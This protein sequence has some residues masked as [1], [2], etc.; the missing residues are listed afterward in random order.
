LAPL[1]PVGGLARAVA[2]DRGVAYLGIGATVLAIDVGVPDAPRILGQ[3][4]ALGDNVFGVAVS[5]P[6]AFVA[7][8]AA[9]LYALDIGD[10]ARI[11]IVGHLDT[12]GDASDVE[13]VPAG[14]GDPAG[15]RVLVADGGDGVRVVDAADPAHL[16]V[17]ATRDTPGFAQALAVE[18]SVAVIGD[19]DGGVHVWDVGRPDAP[20]ADDIVHDLNAGLVV[21]DVAIAG[22]TVYLATRNRGLCRITLT[23]GS[24][25]SAGCYISVANDEGDPPIAV[26]TAGD[27]VYV[28]RAARGLQWVDGA[29][30]AD[31]ES[32]SAAIGGFA[33]PA[34]L[35]VAGG[36]A[37]VADAPAGL[38]VID[39]TAPIPFETAL[40]GTWG[41][42][43]AVATGAGRAY[44]ATGGSGVLVAGARAPDDVRLLGQHDTADALAALRVDGRRAYAGGGALHVLDLAD[45][46]RP[47]LL[48][49]HPGAVRD[50]APAGEVVLAVGPDHGLEV[51][52]VRVPG[53][54]RR[55]ATLALPGWPLAIARAGS[56]AY[57]ACADAGLVVVDVADPARP[58][59]LREV[60]LGGGW[61]RG[62]AIAAG[63]AYVAALGDGV[64]VLD[65]ADPAVPREVALLDT[66]GRATHVVV[67]GEIAVV[68]DGPGGVV[69]ADV[70]DPAAPRLLAAEAAPDGVAAV[71]VDGTTVFAALGASGW[72][73]YR[74]DGIAPARLTPAATATQPDPTPTASSLA[75]RGPWRAHL[76][77]VQRFRGAPRP[78]ALG[79]AIVA[80]VGGVARMVAVSG[81]YAY[82]VVGR[83][84][85]VVD[86][87]DPARPRVTGSSPLLPEDAIEGMTIA[88]DGPFVVAHLNTF[89]HNLWVLDASDPTAP[90]VIARATVVFHGRLVLA[91][92]MLHI[93]TPDGIDLFD[94][95]DPS[96]PLAAIGAD[97]LAG[98]GSARV[99]VLDLAVAGDRAFCLAAIDD[100]P[101]LVTLDVSVP[102]RARRLGV[103]GIDRVRANTTLTR[104]ATDGRRL[105]AFGVIADNAS[106]PVLDVADP[107]RP[108]LI[109]YLPMPG[110]EVLLGVAVAGSNLAIR[111]RSRLI[112]YEASDPSRPREI[113]RL[114][115]AL[116]RVSLTSDTMAVQGMRTYIASDDEGMEIFDLGTLGQVVRL[117][118]LGTFASGDKVA[119]AGARAVVAGQVAG[120]NRSLRALDLADPRR[121][122]ETASYSGP[123]AGVGT[124]GVAD[125]EIAGD[126]AYATGNRLR[127]FDLTG[128]AAPERMAALEGP[129]LLRYGTDA[130][131]AVMPPYALIAGTN[132]PGGGVDFHLLVCDVA[133]PMRPFFVKDEPFAGLGDPTAVLAGPPYL[134][135]AT[136][137]GRLHVVH[138]AT[139]AAARIA[140]TVRAGGGPSSL[141]R[142]GNYLYVGDTGANPGIVVVDVA[143]PESPRMLGKVR[144]RVDVGA[145]AVEGGALYAA[146]AGENGLSS[147]LAVLDLA[148]PVLPAAVAEVTFGGEP[149]DVAA[150]GSRVYVAVRGLGY[151]ARSNSG[152]LVVK[153]REP[154]TD[155]AP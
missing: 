36:F 81:R 96:R 148:D 116:P 33:S 122:V 97:V 47:R 83:R 146:L 144:T 51:V 155:A 86:V 46:D 95:R 94:V 135:V 59:L 49:R 152:L 66:P 101:T 121:P 25:Q 102:T 80:Q 113:G 73:A 5:R 32:P 8:G 31:A 57:V 64:R 153:V 151:G 15:R 92:G 22:R 108:N 74:L 109:G 70:S 58:R 120:A 27:R 76:P 127:V 53:A 125:V 82:V 128:P 13:V 26:D 154:A 39:L 98:G 18:G 126:H 7:A 50:L 87:A 54:P 41:D 34:A 145:L 89:G 77:L 133:T 45:P 55:L 61:A 29:S 43:R 136:A 35:A 112:V 143:D 12:P 85:D 111:T 115:V 48:G 24:N 60:P 40:L 1:G 69:V 134:F 79:P 38:R 149:A 10:P 78:A 30:T 17:T 138:I 11:R 84:I 150:R 114:A 130:P 16:R 28:L 124:F 139:P 137:D 56:Y 42:V 68:A 21:S 65:L 44:A 63:H 14:D 147:A 20:R 52:D 37:Y 123:W 140:A 3:S 93:P 6:L 4:P 132:A 141:A 9:G 62:V 91:G 99:S 106:L 72:M 103:L 119:A 118:T 131:I 19:L 88:A 117:G 75:A 104:L 2:V 23:P 67:A 100:V 110:P 105:I 142:A 71:A 90:T 107:A 129:E